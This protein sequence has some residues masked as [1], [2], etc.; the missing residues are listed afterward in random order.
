MAIRQ[1]LLLGNPQLYVESDP[2]IIEELETIQSV[3][4]DLH[5]MLM[6]FRK[7]YG[8]VCKKAIK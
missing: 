1:V 7:Q 3:V 2:V 5:N 8:A 4:V 6:N